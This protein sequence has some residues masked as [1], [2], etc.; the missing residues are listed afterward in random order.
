MPRRK[1]V[2]DGLKSNSAKLESGVDRGLIRLLVTPTPEFPSF[3]QGFA[4]VVPGPKGHAKYVINIRDRLKQAGFMFDAETK[5][6][7]KPTQARVMA[8][9]AE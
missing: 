5:A 8:E 7:F 9:V 2:T 3:Q 1:S 4:L 6:W